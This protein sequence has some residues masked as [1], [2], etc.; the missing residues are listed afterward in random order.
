V[1]TLDAQPK[2]EN[3]KREVYLLTDG[4]SKGDWDN[5]ESTAE[6]YNVRKVGLHVMCDIS[7]A[8]LALTAH[9]LSTSSGMDF[10]DQAMGYKERDKSDIKV[11]LMLF[12]SVSTES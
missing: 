2:I 4:E 7:L 8:F 1:E 9:G 10:D 6:R 3:Y 12:S 5:W 11:S